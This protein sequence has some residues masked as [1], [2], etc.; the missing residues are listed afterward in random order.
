MKKKTLVTVLMLGLFGAGS[1]LADSGNTNWEGLYAGAHAGYAD[2]SSKVSTSTVFSS[3]GYFASSSV[4]AIATAGHGKVSP[5]SG[6]GGLDLGYNWQSDS[7]V[8]GLEVDWD[9]LN[10][11][12]SRSATATYPCCAPT[13]FT[14]TER[15]KADSMW[16]ARG[17]LGFTSGNSLFYV[18][19]G[20]AQAK[21]RVRDNFSDTFANAS[22]SFSRSKSSSKGIWGVGYEYGFANRWSA[23]LEYLHSDLGTFSGTSTNLKAFS[24]S[25]SFP[26]NVFTHSAD[27]SLNVWRV[28]INYRF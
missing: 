12:D 3:T 23:R 21:V 18:T 5:S 1:A 26:S 17:R 7:I 15:T 13:A 16:T 27:M 4:P 8:F 28:G 25:V 6:L 14:V 22:E 2:G 10:A 11:E 9:A 24:P 19:G 20:W